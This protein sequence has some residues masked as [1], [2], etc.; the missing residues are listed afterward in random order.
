MKKWPVGKTNTIWESKGRCGN[1]Y[2]ISYMIET[3]TVVNQDPATQSSRLTKDY[4]KV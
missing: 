3:P 4:H 2:I 1:G